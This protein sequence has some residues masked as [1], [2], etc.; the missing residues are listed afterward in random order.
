MGP[1]IWL[2]LIAIV[3]MA[4]E[5]YQ[6]SLPQ[7]R[8]GCNECDAAKRREAERQKELAHD[9]EHRLGYDCSNETC[10]RNRR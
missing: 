7:Y 5:T 2:L 4:Y 3:I 6:S 9:Y 10:E 8:K 1:L